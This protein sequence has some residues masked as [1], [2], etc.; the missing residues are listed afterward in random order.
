MA[1]SGQIAISPHQQFLQQ[2]VPPTFP[3][4][5]SHSPETPFADHT[6]PHMVILTPTTQDW[7]ELKEIGRLEG[8]DLISE[9]SSDEGNNGSRRASVVSVTSAEGISS[10]S[11]SMLLHPDGRPLRPPGHRP[12][13]QQAIS[14]DFLDH[15][16]THTP[17]PGSSDVT[18]RQGEGEED[19]SSNQPVFNSVV[20]APSPVVPGQGQVPTAPE[21][22][23]RSLNEDQDLVPAPLEEPMTLDENRT[24]NFAIEDDSDGSP[25]LHGAE[26]KDSPARFASIGRRDSLRVMKKV[27]RT[28]PALPRTK[29]KRELEREKL[30]K[31][32][33]EELEAD[34]EE[35]SRP[36]SGDSQKSIQGQIQEI[37]RGG[38]ASRSLSADAVLEERKPNIDDSVYESRST[39][40]PLP[41]P[42]L[43]A[44]TGLSTKSL[45]QPT[46]H[47]FKPSPLHASPLT[48]LQGLSAGSSPAESPGL[49]SPPLS[50][51][52]PGAHLDSIRDYAKALTSHHSS[53]ASSRV[54]SRVPSP[55]GKT[56]ITS[57][58]PPPKTPRSP[59]V[60]DTSRIS[61]VAGRIVQPYVAP[62]NTSLPPSHPDRPS[63]SSQKSLQSFSPFRSPALGARSPSIMPSFP[64]LESTVSIAPST[65]APSECSTPTSETAGGLGGR[66]I[67]DYVI[68]KEAGKGAYG[69]V[70][71]AKV[72]GP[73]GDPVGV[74]AA[75]LSLV[76]NVEVSLVRC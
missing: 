56:I 22:P 14:A 49:D 64:R 40:N 51:I 53:Q 24:F 71:R 3:H 23:T 6:L 61:L 11:S 25:T 47:P 62:P 68:L 15:E 74:S 45:L 67:D 75:D 72:K 5:G 54:P 9:G 76:E 2:H 13:F 50:E 52:Q 66:G 12:A 1:I 38:L 59:R 37:G 26:D 34:A 21:T 42:L 32:V 58:S 10:T 16:R 46:S 57:P 65:G 60:R 19:D 31:M 35:E 36:A 30:F 43:G 7:R 27:D 28:A 20:I 73:K 8:E 44:V 18:P 33:D 4:S 29:T 41:H 39:S 69:L 63:L 55:T 48:G 70:M 17:D